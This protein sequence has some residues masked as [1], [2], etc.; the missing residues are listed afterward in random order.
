MKQVIGGEDPTR[1][2]WRIVVS[3]ELR[4]EILIKNHDEESHFGV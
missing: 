2:N 1:M 4:K 3:N